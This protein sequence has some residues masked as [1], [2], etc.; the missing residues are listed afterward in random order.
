MKAYFAFQ[1]VRNMLKAYMNQTLN[2][3]ILFFMNYFKMSQPS[4]A[5]RKS[6]QVINL[7]SEVKARLI[8]LLEPSN[9][10]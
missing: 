2:E 7:S 8:L 1:S 10:N 9:Q 5:A 4:Y 3:K 6:P